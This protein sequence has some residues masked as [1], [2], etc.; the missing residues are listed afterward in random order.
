MSLLPCTHFIAADFVLV[1]GVVLALNILLV[2]ISA[3]RWRMFSRWSI[4]S[5]LS[6]GL[7]ALWLG[8]YAYSPLMRSGRNTQALRGF[9]VTTPK[10]LNKPFNTGDILVT[11]A[12]SAVAISVLSDLPGINCRWSSL[13]NGG[14]DDSGN[15]D[16]IYAAPKAENDILTV[17]VDPGCELS[18]AKGSLKISILP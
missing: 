5:L 6:L 4:P 2:V 16:V 8:S 11:Q 17:R 7:L 1:L 14:L 3:K 12:K 13:R 18:P 10:Y 15:C 9:L